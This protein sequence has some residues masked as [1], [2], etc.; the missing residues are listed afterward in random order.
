[1]AGAAKAM[2]IN[3]LL[4]SRLYAARRPSNVEVLM[5]WSQFEPSLGRNIG[6]NPWVRRNRSRTSSAEIDQASVGKWQDEQERPLEPRDWKNAPVR[7]IDVLLML[8]VATNPLLFCRGKRLGKDCPLAMA[9]II[10]PSATPMLKLD[11]MLTFL[12]AWRLRMSLGNPLLDEYRGQLKK[13]Q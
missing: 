10:V 11:F 7:G 2:R 1:L 8:Y 9:P 5:L 6:S 13:L 12:L 3:P 4:R